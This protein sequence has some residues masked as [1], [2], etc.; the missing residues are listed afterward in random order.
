MLVLF[1]LFLFKKN[2]FFLLQDVVPVFFVP[3]VCFSISSSVSSHSFSSSFYFLFRTSVSIFIIL[4]EY[5][6][7][8][9]WRK[10]FSFSLL[11]FLLLLLYLLKHPPPF[12][13]RLLFS[14]NSSFTV[15][16]F[17]FKVFFLCLLSLC[18]YLV[19]FQINL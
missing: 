12:F 17:S 1:S 19:S 16:F 2:F 14:T 11:I 8:L 6:G 5:N 4:L 18:L 10:S 7:L 9:L 3:Y 13:C 15:F